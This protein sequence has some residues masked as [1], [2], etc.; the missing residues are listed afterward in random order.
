MHSLKA[1]EYIHNK[2]YKGGM[3]FNNNNINKSND[4]NNNKSIIFDR[5]NDYYNSNYTAANNRSGNDNTIPITT[6]LYKEF[7]KNERRLKIEMNNPIDA[8]IINRAETKAT[9]KATYTTKFS[10]NY[11]S[12]IS[13]QYQ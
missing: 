10:V 5:N 8:R 1:T 9:Q 11:T 7:R 6:L 13:Y 3:H 4:I 12:I 2:S